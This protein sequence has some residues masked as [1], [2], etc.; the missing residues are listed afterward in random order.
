MTIES[1]T[2]TDFPLNGKKLDFSD[3]ISNMKPTKTPLLTMAKS[4]GATARLR[5]W[6]T[7]THNSGSFNAQLEGDATMPNKT[8]VPTIT[9]AN[10]MQISSDVTSTSSE[11]NA[12]DYYGRGKNEHN[13]QVIKIAVELKL[14]QETALTGAQSTVVGNN[15]T[16]S[17]L[18]GIETFGTVNTNRGVGGAD[19]GAPITASPTDGTQRPFTEALLKDVMQQGFDSGAEFDTLS[20]SSFQKIAGKIL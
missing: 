1:G 12:T 5:Q 7:D 15:T 8:I 17:Q 18:G 3:L 19:P 16:P 20:N 10:N 13:Y 9:L 6:Q 14:D 2:T 11:A 4:R